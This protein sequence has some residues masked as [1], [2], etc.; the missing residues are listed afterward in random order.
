MSD[1]PLW[2]WKDILEESDLEM[3]CS[4]T[5]QAQEVLHCYCMGL[6]FNTFSPFAPFCR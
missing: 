4:V 2:H 1:I 6:C 5:E 3:M